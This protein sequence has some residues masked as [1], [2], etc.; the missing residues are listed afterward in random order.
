M[1]FISEPLQARTFVKQI[2]NTITAP[3]GKAIP[4]VQ[5]ELDWTP[6]QDVKDQNAQLENFQ[7]QAFVLM[8]IWQDDNDEVTF[9]ALFEADDLKGKAALPGT[10][11]DLPSLLMDF[12]FGPSYRHR[13]GNGHATGG[14]ILFG[15]ASDELFASGDDLE[16]VFNWFYKLQTRN[17]N[18]WVFF[19]NWSNNREFLNRIPLPGFGYYIDNNKWV[20]GLVGIPMVGLQFFPDRIVNLEGFYFPARNVGAQMN[21]DPKRWLRAFTFFQWFN[22]RYFRNARLDNKDRLFYYEKRAGAGLRF[23]TRFG[24]EVT[25]SGGYAWDRF[26]FEGRDYDDRFDSRI[27]IDPGPFMNVQIGFLFGRPP[28]V[29]DGPPPSTRGAGE[30]GRPTAHMGPISELLY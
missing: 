25:A 4:V 21:V 14:N 20:R 23:R 26:F 27:S 3:V 29:P 15:S 7:H 8:P 9:L 5:Y 19:L 11:M 18:S 1:F 22:E 17:K 2:L 10:G 6:K 12:R 24:M 30:P 16:L 28:G 13:F